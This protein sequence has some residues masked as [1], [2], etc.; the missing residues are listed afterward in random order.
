[1]KKSIFMMMAVVGLMAFTA[2]GNKSAAAGAD[3]DSTAV[4]ATEAQA[5]SMTDLI[6]KAKAEGANW[7]VDQWKDVFKQ[8]MLCTK[9]MAIDMNALM[10]KIGTPEAKDLDIEAEGKKL[11]E[12]YSGLM[13][14]LSEFTT[15]A[16]AT[17]NGKKVSDDHEWAKKALEEL[18]I[19]DFK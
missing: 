15:I 5:P 17:E 10:S 11:E 9:P 2:C 8:A 6:A 3:A 14:Q 1:M 7:T 19:P 12:K 18:G 16:E 13:E 4:E